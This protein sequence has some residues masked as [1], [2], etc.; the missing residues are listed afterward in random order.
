MGII[1]AFRE[2]DATV[3]AIEDLKKQKISDIK[4]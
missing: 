2:L 4:V 3:D 1:A